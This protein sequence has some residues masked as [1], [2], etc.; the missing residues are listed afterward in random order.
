MV[1]TSGFLVE[2]WN[3]EICVTNNMVDLRF[4]FYDNFIHS[5]CLFNSNPSFFLNC[6]SAIDFL[7]AFVIT[8]IYL[9]EI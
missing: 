3:S 8:L 4:H 6:N 7:I 9:G 1:M 2:N 5:F